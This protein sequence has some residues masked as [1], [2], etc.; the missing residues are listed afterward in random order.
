MPWFNIDDRMWSHPKFIGLPD[1]AIGLWVRAGAW[2]AGH[3]TDGFV[4]DEAIPLL[5]KRTAITTLVQRGLWC[6]VD[7]GYQF[8]DW[9]DWNR[10][11]EQ[12]EADREAAKER[13]RKFRNRKPKPQRQRPD[14]QSV[15]DTLR[16]ID[17]RIQGGN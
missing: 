6:R 3:L 8:H 1:P 13:Q 14:S 5:G 15:D 12:V 16:S 7:G 17:R 11:R 2:A 4:P 9:A 10:T